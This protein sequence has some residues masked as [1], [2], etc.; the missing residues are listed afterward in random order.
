[1]YEPTTKACQKWERQKVDAHRSSVFINKLVLAHLRR[2]N[3]CSQ[4]VD[5]DW[6][7]EMNKAAALFDA[8][9]YFAIAQLE[10]AAHGLTRADFALIR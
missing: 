4:P 7:D 3:E 8:Q 6:Y 5:W 9:Y 10:L 1:M 2:R